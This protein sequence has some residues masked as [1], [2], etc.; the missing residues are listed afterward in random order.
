MSRD[1]GA[2]TL[3]SR[4]VVEERRA[5][6]YNMYLKGFSELQIAEELHVNQSTISRA[7][8]TRRRENAELFKKGDG[9]NVLRSFFQEEK[10]RYF[11]LLQE[12]WNHY[13]S[14]PE[15]NVSGRSQGLGVIRASLGS[16]SQM[17]GQL[18]KE[19]DAVQTRKE[20][21]EIHAIVERLKEKEANRTVLQAT[22]PT[23]A[24]SSSSTSTAST[25]SMDSS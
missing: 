10:D 3:R 9:Q 4:A 19:L 24:T 13:Y 1:P 2:P 8:E 15:N 22:T 17:A 18:V 12:A 7:L 6:A 5:R 11:D 16:L 21:D 20:L 23:P 14:I 25:G